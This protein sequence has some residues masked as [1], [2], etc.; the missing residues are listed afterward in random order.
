M[1]ARHRA[2]STLEYRGSGLGGR[3]SAFL[4]S[5][6]GRPGVREERATRI[7]PYGQGEISLDSTSSARS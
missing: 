2:S 7:L 4:P 1:E 3:Q 5:P 6:F